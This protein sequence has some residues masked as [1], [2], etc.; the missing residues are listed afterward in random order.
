[1]A[2]LWDFSLCTLSWHCGA[3]FAGLHKT[4]ALST[5]RLLTSWKLIASE[6]CIIR[7]AIS[8]SS[9]RLGAM[10]HVMDGYCITSFSPLELK[11]KIQFLYKQSCSPPPRLFIFFSILLPPFPC[12][13][14]NQCLCRELRR[15][16][17]T[18]CS[19]KKTGDCENQRGVT[20]DP[21]WDLAVPL[22]NIS[23][24]GLK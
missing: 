16:R 17:D 11:R 19:R 8:L 3:G 15:R 24:K 14:W 7:R 10:T 9:L 22:L 21:A 2:F 13:L 12:L 18:S 5:F 20:A 4:Q 23:N 1:M 6:L